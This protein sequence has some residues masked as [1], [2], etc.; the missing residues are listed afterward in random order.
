[1]R[2]TLEVVSM[3]AVPTG[4]QREITSFNSPYCVRTNSISR[5]PKAVFSWVIRTKLDVSRIARRSLATAWFITSASGK[6]LEGRPFH[7]PE[8]VRGRLVSLIAEFV[9]DAVLRKLL[10]R[11]GDVQALL[12]NAGVVERRGD[13]HHRAVVG[14]VAFG[15]RHAHDLDGHAC[16]VGGVGAAVGAAVEGDDVGAGVDRRN[17]RVLRVQL[18]HV[19]VLEDGSVRDGQ[20]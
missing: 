11:A 15:A 13:V 2:P 16:G 7:Q 3:Y 17:H 1:M 5:I 6:P 19:P 18:D 12:E 20:R 9:V 14:V 10:L 8:Q 4:H